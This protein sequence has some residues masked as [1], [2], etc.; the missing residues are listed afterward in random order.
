MTVLEIARAIRNA[1]HAASELSVMPKPLLAYC[2]ATFLAP[3]EG[4]THPLLREY[5]ASRGGIGVVCTEFVRVTSHPLGKKILKKHVVRPSVGALSVQVMGNHLEQMA[6]ATRIVTD[7]GADIVDVNLGCPAP[8][9]VRKGVGSALLKDLSL[10]G[11]VL[12]RMR[13]STHLPLSAK[14]RAGFNDAQGVREVARVVQESGADFLTVHPRRRVDFYKGTADWRIIA[15]LARDLAIPVVGN[16]DI[17]Y[18]EDALRMETETG[19]QA[20][21]LGRP[22]LRNPWIFRQIAA[23]RSGDV[24]VRPDGQMVIEHLT[25]LAGLLREEF[26]ERGALGMLKEQLRYLARAVREDVGF[27]RAVLQAETLNELLTRASSI[28][29]PLSSRQLDL[30]AESGDRERSGSALIEGSHRPF[31]GAAKGREPAAFRE[32]I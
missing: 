16:G 7:G 3:M 13:A 20:V 15:V 19:C 21:M 8:R 12:E 22:A 5:L 11:R 29:A 26:G 30:Q 1:N 2:P 27:G 31:G 23:L 25:Q 18:A 9:A 4:V 28:L 24:P 17:W 32:G 10:L 14:I 6:E